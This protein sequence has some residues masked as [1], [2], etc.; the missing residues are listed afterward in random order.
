MIL[1]NNR[2]EHLNP[3]TSQA[4]KEATPSMQPKVKRIPPFINVAK[5]RTNDQVSF[6]YTQGGLKIRPQI[7]ADHT[8]VMTFLKE[9][10]VEFFTFNPNPVNQAKFV[11]RGLLPNTECEEILAGNL[12]CLPDQKKCQDRRSV[13][14]DPPS[15]MGHHDQQE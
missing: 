1:S 15:I 10:E 12:L 9:Q 7:K 14:G 4:G 6:E 13:F 11:L 8:A 3:E 2:L 5:I